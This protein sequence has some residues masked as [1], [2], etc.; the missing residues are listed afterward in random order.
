MFRLSKS[1]VMS[2]LQCPKRVYLEIHHPELIQ[3]SEGTE[4]AFDIGHEVGEA[5][6]RQ[7][8]QGILIDPDQ[9][10]AASLNE[11]DQQI[12][13]TEDQV[14]FEP[15]FQH[16]SVLIKA[17]VLVKIDGAYNLI[18][19]KASTS[20]KD[21]YLKDMAIQRWVIGGAGV[22]I[23]HARLWHIDNSFVY[24]GD[25]NYAGL[26]SEVEVTGEVERLQEQVP[27]WVAQCQTVL[28]SPVPDVAV[29]QQC[30]DPYE[31]PFLYHC[32]P[33]QTEFP[34]T[35]LPNGGKLVTT[36]LEE[37]F[38]DLRDVPGDRLEK[39]KHLRVW[40]VTKSGEAELDRECGDILRGYRYPRFYLDF[41]TIQF[42]VPIWAGTRPYEQLPFQ[43]S[44]HVETESGRLEHREFLDTIGESPMRRFAES[45]I[46]ALK[47][48]G[49]IFVYSSYEKTTL[50]NL[51]ERFPD[52]APNLDAIIA[53]L[54]DLYPLAKAYYY[55]PA[56]MGHWSIKDVLPT[57][58]PELA[59]DNDSL[60][61]VRDGGGAQVAYREIIAAGTSA[62]RRSALVSDL[63][64]YCARDTLAMVEVVRF[65]EGRSRQ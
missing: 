16:E 27:A 52:L 58:A 40:R 49:P 1:K 34:V 35:I 51:A 22:P 9:A 2:G 12:A 50:R 32:A 6:R 55:H 37:G 62:E 33:E 10:L 18:E 31:C 56:M 3:Y 11:T 39:E 57:I 48:A 25:G 28:A 30:H 47:S 8:P 19:V 44:C 23:L 7:F 65:F 54:V 24:A 38:T 63:K 14:L 53:R 64:N 41:E 4:Q 15:T 42:A 26:F 17:D 46:E 29:G 45:L 21:H 60:G 36:L 61:E 43:W 20:V 13:A 5:A 59:Y